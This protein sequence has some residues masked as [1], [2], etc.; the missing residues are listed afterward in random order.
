[1]NT[2]EATAVQNVS[3]QNND[4]LDLVTQM[5]EQLSDMR[6]TNRPDR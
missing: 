1:M 5:G 3:S 4:W 6:A 2:M